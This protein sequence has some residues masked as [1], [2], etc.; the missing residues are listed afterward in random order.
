M[1]ISSS[2]SRFKP[3]NSIRFLGTTALGLQV[4]EQLFDIPDEAG[5]F[6]GIRIGEARYGPR[7]APDDASGSVPSS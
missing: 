7:H 3:L 5:G 1:R 4:G 6:H 2:P